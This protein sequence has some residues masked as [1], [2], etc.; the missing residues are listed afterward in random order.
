MMATAYDKHIT[1][2]NHLRARESLER[3]I[4]LDPRFALAWAYLSWIYTDEHIYGFNPQPDP[5][6]RALSAGRRGVELGPTNHMVRWLL[7]RV[8]YFCGDLDGFLVEVERSLEIN[9]RDGTSVGLIGLYM[10]LGGLWE[11]GISLIRKAQVINPRYPT[12]YH[13]A[14][15]DYHYGRGEDDAALSEYR[16]IAMPGFFRTHS[17]LACAHAQL[18]H[19]DEAQAALAN[20]LELRPDYDLAQ[21]RKEESLA[22]FAQPELVDRLMD[23]LTRAGLPE[24][25]R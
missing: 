9:P 11:R 2:G 25:Q 4:E 19:E 1:P 13:I 14:L 8:H 3:A 10:A 16:R 24:K 20:L 7:G 12:Y 18:G 23:G 15:G 6:A 22:L 5:M 17:R 21:A